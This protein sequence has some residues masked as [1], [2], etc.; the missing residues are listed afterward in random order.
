MSK[1]FLIL[2][3]IELIISKGVPAYIEWS[4]GMK[5]KDPT[6]ED[7]EGLLDI[8]KPEEF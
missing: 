8:K 4:D 5:L 6:L 3:I 1:S 2:K 7:I